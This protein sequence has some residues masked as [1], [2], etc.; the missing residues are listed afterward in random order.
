MFF[1]TV[2]ARALLLLMSLVLGLTGPT[3]AGTRAENTEATD[4]AFAAL[5]SMPNGSPRPGG[6]L[7][8]EDADPPP[9]NEAEL[10]ERLRQLQKDGANFNAMRHQGTLLAHALRAGMERTALWLLRNGADPLKVLAHRETETA[11]SLARQFKRTEVVQVLETRH[12]FQ[13][14]K[15]ALKP[16]ALTKAADRPSALP[17]APSAAPSPPQQAQ[18]LFDQALEPWLSPN[19]KLVQ[20]WLALAASLSP[21][22]F[23]AV[24]A[25]GKRLRQLPYLLKDVDGGLE[26]ALARLPLALVRQHAQALANTLDEASKAQLDRNDKPRYNAAAQSWPAL[27]QRVNQPL[28]YELGT[29]PRKA[30][31]SRIPPQLWPGL[32]A[33]GYNDHDADATDCLLSAV[34]A[35]EFQALWPDFQRHFTN[36]RERAPTLV[37]QA[38]RLDDNWNACRSSDRNATETAAKLAFL[39]QQGVLSPVAGLPP[40][41]IEAVNHWPKPPQTPPRLVRVPLS[42]R[43]E[44]NDLWLNALLEASERNQPMETVQAVDVPG[45]R[46]CGLVVSGVA[47][48]TYYPTVSDDFFSGPTR[49]GSLNC[50]AVD[51]REDSELW[52][53]DQGRILHGGIAANSSE[54]PLTA[55]LDTQTQQRYLLTAGRTG[56]PCSTYAVLPKA[57]TWDA[58][59]RGLHRVEGPE[60]RLLKDVLLHQCE[61]RPADR[62]AWCDG[63]TDLPSAEDGEQAQATPSQLASLLA[64]LR[65]GDKVYIESLVET[66]GTARRQAYQTAVAALD[67]AEVRRL[68]AAGIAP[69]WTATEI[70]KLA[71]ADLPL[72]D[73]RRRIAVLFANANQLDRVVHRDQH[74]VVTSLMKWLPDPDWGPV[75]RAMER[76]AVFFWHEGAATYLRGEAETANRPQLAC[77]IDHAMGY[78]CGGGIKWTDY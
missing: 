15:P 57:L 51:P 31:A 75:L 23:V 54:H 27:W 49:D 33:S 46:H 25:D 44:F 71:Q 61:E 65:Q 24:F 12:G 20:D 68:L 60:A 73:K 37:L 41:D 34:D 1:V 66:L 7:I 8:P 6:W 53:E 2:R 28:R 22:E 43:L 45:Q 4:A 48:G 38:Y 58:N 9:K 67:H 14:P 10:I 18:R 16:P 35:A 55:V 40:S 76:D 26:N 64:S 56:S 19:A 69:R 29:P 78:L 39:R 70:E 63:I 59:Q 32:F 47:I 50:A 52:Q 77:R 42:C 3:H 17:P 30:L 72:A 36:A 13:P 74:G 21:Q 62:E 5:L 11:H